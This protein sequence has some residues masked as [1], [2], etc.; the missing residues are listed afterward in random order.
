M[1]GSSARVSW[2]GARRFTS[3]A[4]SI[5]SWVKSSTEPL[6]GSAAFATSVHVGPFRQLGRHQLGEV[7]RQHLGALAEL[8]G[9]PLER[10]GAATV[11]EHARAALVER[12]RDRAPQAARGA[13]DQ[14]LSGRRAAGCALPG[15][16]RT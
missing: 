9:E 4:L 12:T 14:G 6:A 8:G 5:C 16:L 15:V 1:P 3:I 13:G 11:E 7:E 2:I 10:L